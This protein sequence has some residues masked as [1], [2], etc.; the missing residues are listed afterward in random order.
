[1]LA[2]AEQSLLASDLEDVCRAP[3]CM[4]L[5]PTHAADLLS[6]PWL[7]KLWCCDLQGFYLCMQYHF[8]RARSSC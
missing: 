3:A 7:S 2:A 1:M 6:L 5:I 8:R 4:C